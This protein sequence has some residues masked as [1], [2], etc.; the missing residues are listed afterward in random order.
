DARGALIPTDEVED[1]D[2]GPARRKGTGEELERIIAKM[3]KSLRNVVNPDAIIEEY[4]ADTLRTYIMFMGPLESSRMWDSK[5]IL[6]NF[7]FLRKAWTYVTDNG[8][9]GIRPTVADGDEPK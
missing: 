2:T 8:E 3:S 4:G 1:S 5:A 7:R 6:G 9:S